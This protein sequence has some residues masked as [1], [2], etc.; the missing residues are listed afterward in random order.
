MA[1]VKPKKKPAKKKPNVVQARVGGETVT[2]TGTIT[3]P[4]PPKKD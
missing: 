3:P 1:D 4:P 2:A